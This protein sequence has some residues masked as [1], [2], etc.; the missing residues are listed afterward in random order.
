MSSPELSFGEERK[1]FASSDAL[2]FVET[3]LTEVFEELG[4]QLRSLRYLGHGGSN[5]T[6]LVNDETVFRFPRRKT[7]STMMEG[8]L[9]PALRERG[10]RVAELRHVIAPRAH[11]DR[12]F[13]AYRYVQGTPLTRPRLEG[14]EPVVRQR[15]VDQLGD[16]VQGM[17]TLPLALAREIGCCDIMEMEE[18]DKRVAE[19]LNILSDAGDR[20]HR[21]FGEEFES[22]PALREAWPCVVNM[23]FNEPHLLYDEASGVLHMIDLEY[24]VISHPIKHYTE[25]DEAF[26]REVAEEVLARVAE[27]RR[28]VLAV[29]LE[30][31]R[32]LKAAVSHL[33]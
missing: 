10:L 6:Y 16:L 22:V 3:L 15:V 8:R 17:E 21:A 32:R 33:V 19:R 11:F 12:P 4:L 13:L 29:Q 20:A 9:L 25:L 26:G 2:A 1:I 7:D 31:F 14:F 23:D 27:P 28:S 18:F 30:F 5:V 24:M